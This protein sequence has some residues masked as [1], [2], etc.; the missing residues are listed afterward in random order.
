MRLAV[1]VF[2]LHRLI[3]NIRLSY[4]YFGAVKAPEIWKPNQCSTFPYL[5]KLGKTFTICY[6]N[7][8]SHDAKTSIS[9][10]NQLVLEFS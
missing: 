2:P 3:I 8:H 1:V 9:F 10:I 4:F 6:A 5:A 7:L